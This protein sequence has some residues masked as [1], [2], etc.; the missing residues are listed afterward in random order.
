MTK[1]I[2]LTRVNYDE[3]DLT[4]D[5]QRYTY[6][7]EL[8]T[9]IAYAEDDD[10]RLLEED[11][12]IDG[13]KDGV[14]RTYYR[15]GYLQIEEHLHKGGIQGIRRYWYENGQ[16]QTEKVYDEH[17]NLIKELRWNENGEL[18]KDWSAG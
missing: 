10:G 9:G 4:D 5:Y 15:S 14:C 2:Q 1:D 12:L 8:F 6:N 13:V 16:L 7:G 11:S 18:I 3:L 17:Q